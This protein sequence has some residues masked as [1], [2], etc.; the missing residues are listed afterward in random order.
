MELAR[1]GPGLAERI[2]ADSIEYS[3]RVDLHVQS[4][5]TR[6]RFL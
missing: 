6:L 2:I 3:V 4:T 1:P 5:A